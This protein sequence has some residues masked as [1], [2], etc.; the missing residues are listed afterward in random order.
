[1]ATLS[2]AARLDRIPVSSI[3]RKAAF[4]IGLGLFFEL[5]DVYL[6]GVLGS[7][8]SEQFHIS[9]VTQSLLL[10]SSFLGMFLGAIFLNR[11]ADVIGRRKAF[12]FNL[13]IYSVFTFLCAFSP[14][15]SLLVLFRFLAGFGIGAEA[16]LCDTYLSEILPSYRRGT[17]MVWAYTLQFCSMPVEG[18]LARW[19]VPT[20]VGMAGWRW[21][22]IIGSLGAVF[23]WALQQFLPESPR[24]LESVGRK[25][26]AEKIMVRFEKHLTASQRV[27]IADLPPAVLAPPQEKLPVSTLFIAQFRRRTILLWVFQILQ[28]FGYYGFGTLVPLVLAQKGFDVHS[29]LT[30]TTL[31]FIGY[32]VGSLI[33]LPIVERIQRKWLIVGTA[34]CMGA[35]GILFGI[36]NSPALIIIFGFLYTLVSNI[37]S[38]A[39]HIF[40]VEIYPT[41]IR[42][43]A[44]GAGYSLS[45]LSSGLMP[46]VLLPLLQTSGATAM[47]SVVAIAMVIVMIDIGGFAPKTTARPLEEL[48]QI[49]TLNTGVEDAHSTSV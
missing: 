31:T 10:G 5:Y 17:I 32:P 28:T 13:L 15:V 24:W 45:R 40:Q 36:S 12:M 37:F 35:F 2:I 7:V 33:S 8:I 4:I 25:S 1:M 3:H 23:A 27:D 49:P 26:E 34:F 9:G 14:N 48:N 6:S 47:F 41:S 21:M 44:S 39:Y 30:Y 29:S 38:N 11:M 20:N 16:P 19:I 46:F 43:T 18:L 22:F 42:A